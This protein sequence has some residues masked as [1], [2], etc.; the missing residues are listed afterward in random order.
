MTKWV[1]IGWS[2]TP[3]WVDDD[4][5]QFESWSVWRP[6]AKMADKAA[7]RKIARQIRRRERCYNVKL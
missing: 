6:T 3:I 1:T 7:Q 4:S 2:A 5:C